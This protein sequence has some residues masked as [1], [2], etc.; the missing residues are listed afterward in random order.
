MHNH[1]KDS[2][3]HFGSPAKALVSLYRA[4]VFDFTKEEPVEIE[5]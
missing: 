1:G 2:A 3:K 5:P 4:L